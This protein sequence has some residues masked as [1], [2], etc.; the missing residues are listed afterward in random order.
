MPILSCILTSCLNQGKFLVKNV[1]VQLQ[2]Y[3][4]FAINVAKKPLDFSS[5]NFYTRPNPDLPRNVGKQIPLALH[6]T[7]PMCKDKAV[8]RSSRGQK[9]FSKHF[10]PSI[11]FLCCNYFV[12]ISFLKHLT[13]TVGSMKSLLEFYM[14]AFFKDYCKQ[15]QL[16]LP[17]K[18]P[19]HHKLEFISLRTFSLHLPCF[20]HIEHWIKIK[21]TKTLAPGAEE[22]MTFEKQ[23]YPFNFT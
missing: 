3:N 10:K 1:D 14:S 18:R 19:S 21:K 5:K 4:K 17:G 11:V 12:S 23:K 7:D 16:A 13:N 2:V 20:Q 8:S 15:L 22:T 6:W 9:A